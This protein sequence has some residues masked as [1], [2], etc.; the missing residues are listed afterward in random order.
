MGRHHNRPSIITRQHFRIPSDTLQ[1]FCCGPSTAPAQTWPPKSNHA[2]CL[3]GA[4]CRPGS[5]RHSAEVPR[6]SMLRVCQVNANVRYLPGIPGVQRAARTGQ[7]TALG[8]PPLFTEH[9]CTCARAGNCRGRLPPSHSVMLLPDGAAA[10]AGVTCHGSAFSAAARH[11]VG[12]SRSRGC[13]SASCPRN[14]R[15]LGE[16]RAAAGGTCRSAASTV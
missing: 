6:P 7:P 12:S 4:A 10:S 3:Q 2:G 5:A 14:Q 15:P 1:S 8:P 16:S 11:N 9:R 13:A